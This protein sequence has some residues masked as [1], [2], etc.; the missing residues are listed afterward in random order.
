MIMLANLSL[1]ELDVVHFF[2]ERELFLLRFYGLKSTS[3]FNFVMGK[4]KQAEKL[5]SN[6]TSC[7]DV[8]GLKTVYMFLHNKINFSL[9]VF[10]SSI[11]GKYFFSSHGTEK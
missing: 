3:I 7:V 11:T 2:L 5:L 1:I 9:S 8:D 10:F 4:E 6:V